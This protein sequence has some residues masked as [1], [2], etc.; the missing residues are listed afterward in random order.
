MIVWPVRKEMV[1]V[2]RKIGDVQC[3]GFVGC[4]GGGGSFGKW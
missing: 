3:A 1:R 4:E 2:E